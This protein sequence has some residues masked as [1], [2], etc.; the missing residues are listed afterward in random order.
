MIGS[1]FKQIDAGLP[2][3]L[4][5]GPDFI[6]FFSIQLDAKHGPW[7]AKRDRRAKRGTSGRIHPPAILAGAAKKADIFRLSILFPGSD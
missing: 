5:T 3:R 4:H 7:C 6:S 2:R 1:F